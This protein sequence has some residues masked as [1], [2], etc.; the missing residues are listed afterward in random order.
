MKNQHLHIGH[1]FMPCNKRLSPASVNVNPLTIQ[2]SMGLNVFDPPKSIE[3]PLINTNMPVNDMHMVPI[4]GIH[5]HFPSSHFIS[6]SI[7]IFL[8]ISFPSDCFR[9][10]GATPGRFKN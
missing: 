9:S 4:A 10:R 6:F 1:I 7:F 2:D 3:I 5:M 8:S